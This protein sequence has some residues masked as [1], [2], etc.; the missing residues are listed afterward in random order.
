MTYHYHPLAL[1]VLG[2]QLGHI[3]SEPWNVQLDELDA[4]NQSRE[5]RDQHPVFSILRRSFDAMADEDQLLFMDV[6]IFCPRLYFYCNLRQGMG[7]SIFK[8]LSL[9]HGE[10][11]DV[12]KRRVRLLLVLK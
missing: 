10:S 4:F 8:W 2:R 1:E 3:N 11:V 12:I 7:G 9:V 5:R 6:A